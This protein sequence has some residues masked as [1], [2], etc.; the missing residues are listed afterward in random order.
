[1]INHEYVRQQKQREAEI[2]KEKRALEAHRAAIENAQK[3]LETERAQLRKSLLRLAEKYNAP[4]KPLHPRPA[5][6]RTAAALLRAAA[7]I[8]ETFS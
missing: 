3:A 1:M 6:K 2:E 8:T 7:L 5:F 4:P